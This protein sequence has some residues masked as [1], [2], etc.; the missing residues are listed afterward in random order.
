MIWDP[1]REAP[2]G[3]AAAAF[4]DL[5]AK[6]AL[7]ELDPRGRHP[8]RLGVDASAAKPGEVA[9][10]AGGFAGELGV[11]TP[12]DREVAVKARGFWR[13]SREHG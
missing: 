4:R 2:G 11:V 7:V 5:L 9:L 3:A 1:A 10:T 6:E 12:E 8:A 13:A